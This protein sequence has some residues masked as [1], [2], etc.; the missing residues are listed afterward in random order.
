MHGVQVIGTGL[1]TSCLLGWSTRF[2]SFYRHLHQEIGTSRFKTSIPT[3]S[4]AI[5]QF[6]SY[7]HNQVFRLSL[8]L[9]VTFHQTSA[10]ACAHT[11]HLR[12]CPFH[13]TDCTSDQSRPPFP[14]SHKPCSSCFCVSN[15]FTCSSTQPPYTVTQSPTHPRQ[16]TGACT[17]HLTVSLATFAYSQP[18]HRRSAVHGSLLRARPKKQGRCLLL[19]YARRGGKDHFAWPMRACDMHVREPLAG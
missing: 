6:I 15:T 7:Y 19:L 10:P 8:G 3:H 5:Y 9:E 17:S 2:G 12:Q 13:R 16:R 18:Y 14:T 4:I 1:P 11:W